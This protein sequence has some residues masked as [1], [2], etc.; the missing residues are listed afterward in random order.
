MTADGYFGDTHPEE[1]DE[2]LGRLPQQSQI[3]KWPVE[4]NPEHLTANEA[5]AF[6][7]QNKDKKFFLG[8][9]FVKPHFPFTIQQKYYDLYSG[10][11]SPPRAAEKLIEELPAV[12][13]RERENYKHAEATQE[14]ILRTKAI[15]YG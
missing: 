15:Y 10:K 12:S 9:S 14:E 6:L 13:K 11:V 3:S 8:V 7:D 2:S 4:K 1:A 5:L